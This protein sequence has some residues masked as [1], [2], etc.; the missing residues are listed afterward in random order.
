MLPKP[1]HLAPQYGQQFED[2][3]IASVYATRPPYPEQVFDVLQ[4]LFPPG[5]KSLLDLGCGTGDIALGMVGRA[6]RID[7]IDPSQAM[8]D[9]AYQRPR[10]NDVSV[11]WLNESAES[12]DFRAP[13]GLVVAAESFH[14][15][16]WPIVI[17]KVARA[18]ESNA[19]LAI[20]KGRNLKGLPWL[21]DLQRLIP[22]F[23]TNQDYRAYDVVTELRTRGLF[24]EVGRVTTTPVA[25]T[26]PLADYVESFHTRNGFSRERMTRENAAAFDQALT[27]L[28][29]AHT[30]DAQIRGW[31]TAEVIW[32]TPVSTVLSPR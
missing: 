3:S 25:F 26:Q 15:M 5:S 4:S 1:K 24:E 16:D 28:V 31:V 8:L 30:P 23:S 14:W 11:S 12:F 21:H 27:E 22:R 10:A 29:L 9:I 6:E 13:Y 19:S 7:A 32:G 17:P 20:V 18:L 2:S